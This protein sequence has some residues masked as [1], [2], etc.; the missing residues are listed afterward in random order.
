M[1]NH[2]KEPAMREFFGWGRDSEMPAVYVHLSGRDIDD[3]VLAIYGNKESIKSQEPVIKAWH[4]KRCGEINDPASKYCKKCGLPVDVGNMD[5]LEGLLVDFLKIIG[6]SFP[7]VREK[8]REVVKERGVEGIFRPYSSPSV[9]WCCNGKIEPLGC[10]ITHYFHYIHIR[11][12]LNR[13]KKQPSQ[14]VFSIH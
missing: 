2:L 5:K 8:F 14:Y 7:Q 13:G 12:P 6:D 10:D 9:F 1:A 3:S 4:C 11:L